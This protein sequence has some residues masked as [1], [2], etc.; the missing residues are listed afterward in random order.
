MARSPG[1]QATPRPPSATAKGPSSQHTAE[2]DIAVASWME[3]TL[4]PEHPPATFPQWL[5]RSWRRLTMLRYGANPHQQAALYSDPAAWPGLAQAEQLHGKEMSYNNF[6]DADAAFD[7]EE[8][9]VA[10]IK[11]AN[12]CG[13]L[14]PVSRRARNP[15]RRRGR[16]DRASRR[17]GARRRGD[18]C[19]GQ[20]GR[21]LVPHRGT[22][23]RSLRPGRGPC[24]GGRVALRIAAAGSAG[25]ADFLA[26][27]SR[28]GIGSGLGMPTTVVPNSRG[29]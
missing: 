26:R 7:H 18:R 13:C 28:T 10:I 12:P 5:G 4:A 1:S 8:T 15:G 23:L 6:T 16:R 29:M 22:P 9:C 20:R 24:A 25:A 19:G 17:L 11:H 3:S 14:L 21:H 27:R 2:Y